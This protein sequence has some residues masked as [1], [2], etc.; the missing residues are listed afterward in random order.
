MDRVSSEQREAQ[1]DLK[2]FKALV[3][4]P[5]SDTEHHRIWLIDGRLRFECP[6][7]VIAEAELRRQRKCQ[8]ERGD[9]AF[10]S[11]CAGFLLAWRD[12]IAGKFRPHEVVKDAIIACQGRRRARAE[13]I[14]RTPEDPLLAF[15]RSRYRRKASQRILEAVMQTKKWWT[16]EES[17]V[18]AEAVYGATPA[19][20]LGPVHSS[21][22][23]TLPVEWLTRVYARGLAVVKVS[24]HRETL[25]CDLYRKTRRGRYIVLAIYPRPDKPPA[26]RRAILDP[27]RKRIVTWL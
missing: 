22:R 5:Y 10:Y 8:S 18:V 9:F 26:L 15:S 25:I 13:A 24:P 19:F 1:V 11:G 16:S 4:C 14:L 7:P 20:D 21:L 12:C 6:V 3:P 27:E 23:F 17:I 2:D